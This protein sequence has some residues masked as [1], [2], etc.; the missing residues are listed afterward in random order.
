[1]IWIISPFF[2]FQPTYCGRKNSESLSISHSNFYTRMRKVNSIKFHPD[3][4]TWIKWIFKQK[5]HTQEIYVRTSSI[6]HKWESYEA[7]ECSINCKRKFLLPSFGLNILF[8]LEYMIFYWGTR[9]ASEKRSRDLVR[10]RP[11]PIILLNQLTSNDVECCLYG[12]SEREVK[13]FQI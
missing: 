11:E 9:R 4:S 5:K 2:N 7:W 10:V 3:Y 8:H 13:D 1:M 12:G 6:Q